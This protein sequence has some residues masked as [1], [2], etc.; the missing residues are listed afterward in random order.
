MGLPTHYFP[1]FYGDFIGPHHNEKTSG[2]LSANYTDD[3]LLVYRSQ[4]THQ[5][6]ITLTFTA[7][8][9]SFVV[10]R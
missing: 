4:Q 7:D 9:V 10:N 8:S 5:S 2:N 1:S 3:F 6:F